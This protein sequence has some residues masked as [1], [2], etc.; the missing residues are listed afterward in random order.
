MTDLTIT[1]P[2]S[3]LVTGPAAT[4]RT[5]DTL[6]DAIQAL[7]SAELGLLIVV[8]HRGSV[9]VLS[10]RDI[11]GAIAADADLDLERVRDYAS[12][13][14]VEVDE[15]V[16]IVEAAR[17][18]DRAAIRHLAI[19]RAGVVTSVVSMRDILAVFLADAA[20]TTEA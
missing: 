2:V 20:A 6:R 18:M 15:D 19:S 12:T 11:V 4:I 13:H 9:A 5:T 7:A 14:I 17:V 8:D 10:E 1:S 16:P 3:R